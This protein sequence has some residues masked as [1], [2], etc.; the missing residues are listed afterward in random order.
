MARGRNITML[1]DL[2][3]LEDGHYLL[4]AVDTEGNTLHKLDLVKRQLVLT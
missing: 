2:D 3:K 1:R 4:D